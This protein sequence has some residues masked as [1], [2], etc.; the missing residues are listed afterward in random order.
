MGAE[1][2]AVLAGADTVT[3]VVHGIGSQKAK[4]IAA[5]AAKG[6]RAS[7]LAAAFRLET[8]DRIVLA[9]SRSQSHPWTQQGFVRLRGE[10]SVHVL[11]PCLWSGVRPGRNA[12]FL[13][14][15][16]ALGYAALVAV[17]ALVRGFSNITL[18]HH[19]WAFG[20]AIVLDLLGQRKDAGPRLLLTPVLALL[21]LLRLMVV[22]TYAWVPLLPAAVLCALGVTIAVP[23]VRAAPRARHL[24]WQALILLLGLGLALLLSGAGLLL[25]NFAVR[26]ASSGPWA[27]GSGW[28]NI[29][30]LT[31]PLL[32][33]AIL[34]GALR[35]SG[36][37]A[38]VELLHD[39]TRYLGLPERRR[40]L[41]ES[42]AGMIADVERLAPRARVQ[43]VSHSL[44][45]VLVSHTLAR[46]TPG[47]PLSLV[48]M[49]SP[50]RFLSRVFPSVVDSPAQL[51]RT[52]REGGRVASWL[53]LWRDGDVVGRALGVDDELFSEGSLGPGGHADYWQDESTWNALAA[54]T[55]G[56][57][58][59]IERDRAASSLPVQL[60]AAALT[61]A[62]ALVWA[63]LL[64]AWRSP[65]LLEPDPVPDLVPRGR[66]EVRIAVEGTETPVPG[67]LVE[68][69]GRG[70]VE[71]ANGVTDASGRLAFADLAVQSYWLEIDRDQPAFEPGG[72]WGL[73]RPRPL[74]LV[75]VKRDGDHRLTIP[76]HP[77]A[78]VSGRIVGV[79]CGRSYCV[80]QTPVDLARPEASGVFRVR[81]RV[82]DEDSFLTVRAGGGSRKFRIP[83]GALE[84]GADRQ[85]GELD[86]S[87]PAGDG[88]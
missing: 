81:A 54:W 87:P 15:A 16:I 70:D 66:V 32:A 27:G 31:G 30:V 88:S 59:P 83:G 77:T 45:S 20:A 84:L 9:R 4:S 2:Q 55:T 73:Y 72:R 29:L 5:S 62:V 67:V 53:N 60:G 24:G 58:L 26:A 41:E 7:R 51:A 3:L 36:A 8:G 65:S 17:L 12:A 71:V 23:V 82:D 68:V 14:V 22:H 44:G 80:A 10:A 57:P 42:L 79:D 25:G 48:T 76:L 37:L 11:L 56:E 34:A 86:L 33:L 40:Q 1:S 49:G 46:R 38:A 43:V 63:L 39:V 69:R 18:Q 28:S 13:L 75:K 19:L 61:A 50:L 6:F 35:L 21:A 47:R 52:F 64:L 78:T 85:L 74:W